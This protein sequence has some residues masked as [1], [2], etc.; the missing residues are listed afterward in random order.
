M[1]SSLLS[2]LDRVHGRLHV[3]FNGMA[4]GE[5][6]ACQQGKQNKRKQQVQERARSRRHCASLSTCPPRIKSAPVQCLSAMLFIHV[7]EQAYCDEYSLDVLPVKA[8]DAVN[9][10][11][12]NQLEAT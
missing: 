6:D 1:L 3:P 2:L 10:A 8:G 4:C 9:E 7:A 12:G 11:V 5:I